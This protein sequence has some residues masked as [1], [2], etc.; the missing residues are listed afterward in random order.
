MR[1][2]KAFFCR[3]VLPR[4]GEASLYL[5]NVLAGNQTITSCATQ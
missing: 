2:E 1:W 4:N 5:S 3:R